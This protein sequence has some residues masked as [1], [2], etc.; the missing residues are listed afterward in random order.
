MKEACYLPGCQIP[1]NSCAC[2]LGGWPSPAPHG[3]RVA[4]TESPYTNG[5]LSR[6]RQSN[7]HEQ[8]FS[9]PCS[10][11]HAGQG[12]GAVCGGCVRW[13]APLGSR[14]WLG[15]FYRLFPFILF[16][17]IAW[18]T[19]SVYLSVCLSVYDN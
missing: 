12:G 2:F 14:H 18:R 7:A 5:G 9:I 17:T 16:E 15:G 1:G 4:L 10:H 8:R 6:P 13:N 19:V 3:W 11:R